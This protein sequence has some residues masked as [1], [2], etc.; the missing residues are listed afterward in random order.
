MFVS[1]PGASSSSMP[2]EDNAEKPRKKVRKD[3]KP[4]QVKTNGIPKEPPTKNNEEEDKMMLKRVLRRMSK[5]MIEK[6]TLR[7]RGL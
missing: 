1:T 4:K 7:M 3:K 2:K 6:M 5:L